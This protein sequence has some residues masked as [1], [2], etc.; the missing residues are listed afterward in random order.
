[1]G[2]RAAKSSAGTQTLPT[3]LIKRFKTVV[4]YQCKTYGDKDVL[5]LRK[6]YEEGTF[7]EKHPDLIS[8]YFIDLIVCMFICIMTFVFY[9]ICC[10]IEA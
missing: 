6:K 7:D 4:G 9:S 3:D 5:A 8:L 2:K 10:S 1:M